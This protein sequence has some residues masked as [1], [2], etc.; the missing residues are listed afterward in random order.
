[1]KTLIVIAL[2]AITASLAACSSDDTSRGVA[3]QSTPPASATESTSSEGTQATYDGPTIPEGAYRKEVTRDDIKKAGLS[4]ADFDYRTWPREHAIV[5]YRFE[6]DSWT[7]FWGFS[8]STLTPGSS[9]TL[10]YDNRG[11]LILSEPCCGETVIRWKRT[12]GKLTMKVTGP[13]A[14]LADPMGKIMRDGT[15]AGAE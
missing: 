1:M 12:G 7:Q 3:D 8:E 13:E 10:S 6:G 15:Y 9:G 11:R 5:T 2:T 4:P 14:A